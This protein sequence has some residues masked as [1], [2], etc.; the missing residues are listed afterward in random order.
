[1]RG[2]MGGGFD[3]SFMLKGPWDLVVTTSANQSFS[4]PVKVEKDDKFQP[5]DMSF[6]VLGTP[7]TV[8][9]Q[10]YLPDLA[11]AP[12]VKDKP[13][14][15]GI[16]QLVIEGPD[17][18]QERWLD[19]ADPQRLSISSPIGRVFLEKYEDRAN[20]PRNLKQLADPESVGVMKIRLKELGVL[21]EFVIKPQQVIS[22]PGTD[23]RVTI[24]DFYPHYSHDTETNVDI[25]LSDQ[26][27]NPAIKVKVEKGDTSYEKWL[28][29][30][31]PSFVHMDQTGEMMAP[32]SLEMNYRYFNFF[33]TTQ[34]YVMVVDPNEQNWML[35]SEKEG[36]RTEK[37]ALETAYPF[38]DEY[39]FT[40]KQIHANAELAY[41]WKNATEVLRRPAI[42]V[43]FDAG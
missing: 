32:D 31:F 41:E 4:F 10:H 21:L 19:S 26:P 34:N 11:W 6:P 39:R 7:I 37:L 28:W 13:N 9:L 43:L 17:L 16:V 42:V 18:E 38:T 25:N 30:R 33:G 3:H 20:F 14:G 23:Y 1:M 5:L 40:V 8:Q 35:K 36:F 12:V 2:Q 22:I 15:A 29:A 27:V 24:M